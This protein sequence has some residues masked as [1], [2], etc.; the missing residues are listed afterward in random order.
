VDR[1]LRPN[2]IKKLIAYS[3]KQALANNRRH[4]WPGPDGTIALAQAVHEKR[5]TVILNDKRFS[6]R[7]NTRFRHTVFVKPDGSGFRPCGYF[8]TN[9]LEAALVELNNR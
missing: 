3:S 2:E 9:K 1:V 7:Y 4:Y 8:D 5:P 6:I